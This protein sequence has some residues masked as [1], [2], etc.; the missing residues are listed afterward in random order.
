MDSDSYSYISAAAGTARG[1]LARYDAPCSTLGDSSMSTWRGARQ[2]RP[3]NG[4][5][6]VSIVWESGGLAVRVEK[7]LD[8]AQVKFTMASVF[9]VCWSDD[10]SPHHPVRAFALVVTVVPHSLA[11][12]DAI[13]TVEKLCGVLSRYVAAFDNL[14]TSPSFV[15]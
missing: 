4:S 1:H 2:A 8:D 15:P 3:L 9:G 10:L 5:E 6:P 14:M 11:V 12:K 13:D 7:L